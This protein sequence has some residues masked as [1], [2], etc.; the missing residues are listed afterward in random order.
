MNTDK[1]K[2]KNLGCANGW[3]ET[4]EIV[5]NCDHPKDGRV[6][7]NCYVETW[8]RICGYVYTVDSSG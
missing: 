3:R 4:P 7:G 1:D 2:L 8:C 5:K 6:I